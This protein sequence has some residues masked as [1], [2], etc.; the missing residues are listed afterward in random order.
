MNRPLPAGPL[1]E[2]LRR[3]AETI[4]PA[5][6]APAVTTLRAAPANDNQPDFFVPS[7]CDIALKDGIGLMDIACFRL[8]SK[9]MTQRIRH[10]L[11]GV[12]VEVLGGR[13]GLATIHDYD[14]V[15]LMISQLT[16]AMRE[17]RAGRG[18]RPPMRLKLHAADILA[19]CRR[20]RGG[21]DYHLIDGA[22][23]RLH[24]TFIRIEAS[25]AR[26]P[27]RRTGYFSLL[28]DAEILSRADNGR[29]EEVTLGIPSWLYSG[30]VDS[31]T[32]EVLTLHR[33]YL[34][35][36]SGMARFVYRLARK[37]AGD[38]N[39]EYGFGLIHARSGSERRRAAF[40]ADL[41]ALIAADDLP[42][43][44]LAERHGPSGS[45]LCMVRRT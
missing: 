32:P 38:G 18:P 27:A 22:L 33:D 43:Y 30:V 7:L 23:R 8:G 5:T 10:E 13:D 45:V 4:E 3:L 34:L 15:L 40:D 19:F 24:G 14:I 39:A 6:S 17:W 29:I 36:K 2:A 11:P 41:R 21:R 28:S 25:G 42:D 16:Q 37:A 1:G 20:G 44:R 9:S 31:R 12:T 35:I 26:T